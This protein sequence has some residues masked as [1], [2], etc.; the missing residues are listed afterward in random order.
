MAAWENR[1]DRLVWADCIDIREIRFYFNSV[2]AYC[3]VPR[4]KS[5]SFD[6]LN[7]LHSLYF[8]INC[9]I[10]GYL[11][12]TQKKLGKNVGSL[13]SVR[14]SEIR[15]SKSLQTVETGTWNSLYQYLNFIQLKVSITRHV[16]QIHKNIWRHN[17]PLRVAINPVPKFESVNTDACSVKDWCLGIKER[18][19]CHLLRQG[20]HCSGVQLGEDTR[21]QNFDFRH[22]RGRCWIEIQSE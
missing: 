10:T 9:E 21:N 4:T 14:F 11:E 19:L 7:M 13:R 8:T 1:V 16:T 20:G 5:S 15:L 6:N 18:N 3:R 12:F 22:D 2:G 17:F